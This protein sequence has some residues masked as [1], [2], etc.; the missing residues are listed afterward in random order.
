MSISHECSIKLPS[1]VESWVQDRLAD[2]SGSDE[3][4]KFAIALAT[5]NVRQGTGGPFGA[6]VINSEN[7]QLVS[8][9]VN[10]V[11]SSG[12]SIAHAEMVAISLA[13][14]K[15]GSW[16]LANEGSFTLV[17]TCEPCAMCFGAVPWSGVRKLVCGA[18]KADAQAAGFD[19]GDKPLHWEQ[20]LREREIEV[21]TGVMREDAVKIF[22]HYREAG[23]VIYNAD[24][25]AAP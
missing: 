25:E 21:E 20:S 7:G 22:E 4:M 17:T 3:G 14:H 6:A 15:L 18:H 11:T 19:E 12:M 13:Q 2:L 1:W 23:G 16:N 10:L 5:E 8:V 9:G 24:V